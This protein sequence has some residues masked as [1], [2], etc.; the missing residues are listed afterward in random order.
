[1]PQINSLLYLR[2]F[3]TQDALVDEATQSITVLLSHL[4]STSRERLD[5]VARLDQLREERE[6][7]LQQETQA[8]SR[9]RHLLDLARD[10]MALQDSWSREVRDLYLRAEEDGLDLTAATSLD[11]VDA[12]R[13]GKARE[14]RTEEEIEREERAEVFSRQLLYLTHSTR[15]S[16][17]RVHTLLNTLQTTRSSLISQAALNQLHSLSRQYASQLESLALDR[18]RTM[19]ALSA[20]E[21]ERA[22]AEEKR[23]EAVLDLVLEWDEQRRWKRQ[24]RKRRKR[25]RRPRGLSTVLRELEGVALLLPSLPSP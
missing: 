5:L 8:Q 10:E 2:D 9:S 20:R 7:L 15:Q 14:T 25:E 24:E 22:V 21:K 23:D 18:E 1:M 16:E 3:D 11:A 17:T 12:A 4:V 13:K 19:T 6:L